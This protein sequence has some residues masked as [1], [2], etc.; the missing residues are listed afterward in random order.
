MELEDQIV[1]DEMISECRT[2]L[3]GKKAGVMIRVDEYIRALLAE[4]DALKEKLRNWEDGW[5]ITEE[6]LQRVQVSGSEEARRMALVAIS[7]V[8][9]ANTPHTAEHVRLPKNHPYWTVAHDDVCAAV[10]REMSLRAE[11]D[12]LLK[13][14]DVAMITAHRACHNQE[15]D[16]GNGK[17]AGYCVVC[18]ILWPCDYADPGKLRA[19]LARKTAECGEKMTINLPPSPV[20]PVSRA[21]P[22]GSCRCSPVAPS[23]PSGHRGSAHGCTS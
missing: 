2:V 1:W 8:A 3:S 7:V 11:R 13:R 22:A 17:L 16:P 12:A 6:D 5:A 23:S 20:S 9:N 4:R 19:D 18:G 14:A 21:S 10:D 15:Q